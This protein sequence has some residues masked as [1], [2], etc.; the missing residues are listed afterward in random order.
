MSNSANEVLWERAKAVIPG[1]VDSPDRNFSGINLNLDDSAKKI[2]PP[3]I[4]SG[5]GSR[6]TDASGKSYVD[7]VSGYGS[8]ILGHAHPK[9]LAAIT[10]AASKGSCFGSNTAGEVELAELV[11][12]AYPSVEKLRLVT[13]ETEAAICAIRLARGFTNRM[14]I[15]KF[16]GCYHGQDNELL[17]AGGAGMLTSGIP[18]SAGVPVQSVV[19]THVLQ[20]SNIEALHYLFSHTG[21][22]IACVIVEPIATSM[23]L[24]V[25]ADGFLQQV[26]S[27]TEKYGALLIFDEGATG[28][29][30]SFG[31]AQGKTKIKPDLT[32]FG[33]IIGGGIPMAAFGGRADIMDCSAPDGPVFQQDNLAGNSVA[34]AAGLETLKIL[35]QS[36]EIYTHIFSQA[37][38]IQ[39]VFLSAAQR[40]GIPVQV[41][42]A[43]S[44]LSCFFSANPVK[45]EADAKHSDMRMFARLYEELLRK[46]VY[47]SPTPNAVM[48]ISSTLSSEDIGITYDAISAAF[49]NL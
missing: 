31:G 28:F 26:R 7:Y 38:S 17:A 20:Y 34:V 39:A 24:V 41:P 11:T 4:V 9:V 12:S 6:I 29:R 10:E 42:L 19:H 27:V 37:I 35:Q 8:M 45:N 22:K 36:P 30:H 44:M 23:G 32:I 47:I 3:Y 14:E 40:K 46:G 25:P 18:D 49:T 21:E 15:V 5:K 13:S 33:R 48:Y 1:G 43:G 16:A 2:C